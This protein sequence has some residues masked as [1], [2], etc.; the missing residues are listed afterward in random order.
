MAGASRA[1]EVLLRRD[2]E[3]PMRVESA[4][5]AANETLFVLSA[6]EGC[7]PGKRCFPGGEVETALGIAIRSWSGFRVPGSCAAASSVYFPNLHKARSSAMKVRLD[8]KRNAIPSN[9]QGREFILVEAQ[10][11]DTA[12]E[13]AASASYCL[14]GKEKGPQYPS[15]RT[16]GGSA[17]AFDGG[18]TA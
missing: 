9:P 1:A 15:A 16:R 17:S 8:E 7:K 10:N 18:W 4:S 13:A 3:R 6:N 12:R 2:G 5:A 11:A 14:G